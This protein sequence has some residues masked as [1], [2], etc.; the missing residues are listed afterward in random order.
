MAAT[1]MPYVISVLALWSPP[2]V[3][4]RDDSGGAVAKQNGPSSSQSPESIIPALG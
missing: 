1:Y 3:S 2:L 4:S